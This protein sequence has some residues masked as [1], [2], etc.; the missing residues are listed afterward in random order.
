ML[1][2]KNEQTVTLF[3]WSLSQNVISKCANGYGAPNN[4][5]KVYRKIKI[6]SKRKKCD[7]FTGVLTY[8]DP[9]AHK[10]V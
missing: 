4:E 10:I 5:S 8:R 6:S 7:L 3:T 9:H 2:P 1:W